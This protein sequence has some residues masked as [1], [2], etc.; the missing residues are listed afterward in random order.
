MSTSRPKP[1]RK[2][3][4]CT[5]APDWLPGLGDIGQLAC[6][7]HDHLYVVGGND[8]D[9]LKADLQLRADIRAIALSRPATLFDRLTFSHARAALIASLYYRAVRLFGHRFFNFHPPKGH[10]MK[11]TEV[12]DSAT[13]QLLQL[14]IAID[15]P[16]SIPDAVV[17]I[18]ALTRAICEAAL[19][20]PD[21]IAPHLLLRLAA[22]ALLLRHQLPSQSCVTS[23]IE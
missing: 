3:N 20:H 17:H 9:R 21:R 1:P 8:S 16:G 22:T 14:M 7:H 23:K 10:A 6:R 18:Q 2:R 4:Y 11:I 5:A 13:P 19:V 15:S 12:L